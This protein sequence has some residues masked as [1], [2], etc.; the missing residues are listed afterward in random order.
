MRCRLPSLPATA[1]TVPN[2]NP[3]LKTAK[4]GPSIRMGESR[5]A[6]GATKFRTWWSLGVRSKA[7]VAGLALVLRSWVQCGAVLIWPALRSRWIP[8]V[9]GNRRSLADGGAVVMA[10]WLG[11]NGSWLEHKAGRRKV[12]SLLPVTSP[13]AGGIHCLAF[14]WQGVRF[15][16]KPLGFPLRRN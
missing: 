11:N 12:R 14:V 2:R 5:W 1:D 9:R 8:R 3:V 4:Q 10:R 6:D 7:T 15:A 16:A 13:K